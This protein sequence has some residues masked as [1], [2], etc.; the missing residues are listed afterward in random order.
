MNTIQEVALLTQSSHIVTI[1]VGGVPVI[2]HGNVPEMV[3]MA[4]NF[5]RC[6]CPRAQLLTS[7]D[8]GWTA[9]ACRQIQGLLDQLSVKHE[10]LT[11]VT[12]LEKE[13]DP[14]VLTLRRSVTTAS[15]P[16]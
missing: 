7:N 15:T 8:R 6:G 13:K 14:Q 11:V 2:L 10:R 3:T 5:L 9:S 4:A 12:D 1:P 16:T